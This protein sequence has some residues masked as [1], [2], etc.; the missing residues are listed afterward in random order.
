MS[1]H[2]VPPDVGPSKTC[3]MRNGV[4]APLAL[5]LGIAASG[6]VRQELRHRIVEG[7]S[8]IARDAVASVETARFSAA[9]FRASDGTALSYRFLAPSHPEKGK[10]YPLVLQLHGS[11]G[12]GTDNMAQ[13][14]RLARTWAMPDV[15]DRYQAYV[16]VP[17]FPTRSAN[18]GPAAADQHSEP[19]A[20][21]HAALELVEKYALDE[22]V[23]RSRIY[24]TGFSMGGSAAWLS[25]M[26][27]PDLFAAIVPISG[28]APD[29]ARAS[30]FVHLPV[31]VIHGNADT[32]NPIASDIRFSHE[33]A[34]LGGA[35]IEFR[36][37]EG[38]DH[39]MPD[40][41]LPGYWWR[42]WLF[43]QR[44]R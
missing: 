42:D 34:R 3:R 19:S 4:A 1:G 28:I 24:A 43:S 7:H 33:I 12:I 27:E 31:L 40:D 26:L 8:P 10:R 44:R 20:A 6:C 22:P 35:S 15:R 39:Q 23:D 38:L 17:Q 13:L 5:L 2:D 30:A 25:P 18:Y 11:G 36:E 41:I 32:E 37:Y 21:L 9:S 29:N 14:D 16:L